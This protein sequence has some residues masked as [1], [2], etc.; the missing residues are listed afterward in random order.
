MKWLKYVVAA[1]IACIS[2][3]YLFIV[4]KRNNLENDIRRAVY[5]DNSDLLC[6]LISDQSLSV[7]YL[8]YPKAGLKVRTSLLSLA[9]AKNSDDCVRVLVRSG[10]NVNYID[11]FGLTPLH[12]A[13]G[14]PV[15]LFGGSG[16]FAVTQMLLGA[17]AN[18]NVADISGNTP[19]HLAA[20]DCYADRL[21][22]LLQAGGNKNVKNQVGQD[23]MEMTRERDCRECQ[24]IL[25]NTD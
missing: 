7:D 18:V 20:R 21:L 22:A 13:S 9:A 3:V 14:N 2:V 17:G 1:L 19:L 10:A 8:I 4:L 15:Y 12:W 5:S 25:L 24:L 16:G 6:K 11:E 23:V